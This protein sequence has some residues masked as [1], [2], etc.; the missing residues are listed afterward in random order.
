MKLFSSYLKE[1][2][3][4][5]RGFYFYIEIF[6]AVLILVILLFAVKENPVTSSKEFIYYEMSNELK[7][8]L[9]D[10]DIKK[11]ALELVEPTV[12]KMKATT[13]EV[14]NKAT[15]DV[16][17]YAFDKETYQLETYKAYDLTS[18]ELEKTIYMAADEDEMIR[19]THQEKRIG[20]T[21]K[22]DDQGKSSYRYYNQGYE[23]ERYEN[24]L[25]VLH[26]ENPDKL[27]EVY[28]GQEITT[29][30][31]TVLLNN[32]ENLVPVMIIL[33][34]SLM[35]FF[36]VMAYIFLDKDEDVIRAYAVT[37][38][39]VWKYLLSK[40]MVIMTTV[41]ISSSI[42]TIPI[43]G[44]QANYPLFYILLLISTFA[45]SSLGLLV[46]SFFD[47]I[48]KAFGVLYAFVILMMLPALSYFLPS[49]DPLWL[50]LFPTYPLLQAMKEILMVKTDVGYVL[51]YSGVFLAGGILLFFLANQR[52][53][54][55]LTV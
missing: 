47:N 48:S 45:F 2:K 1:M 54:K 29:L 22:I 24:L 5:A 46:A 9:I 27:Q 23:T 16:T 55:S 19:L 49:Y 6:M 32:R 20:A 31:D 14:E 4:A 42:I 52:F 51:I 37:P 36:I 10:D 7:A 17:S 35:S 41:L 34:G 50:R 21:I 43:M 30:G 28:E 38:S 15:G 40:T 53:R 33:M 44:A 8:S 12:F 26:N 39:S 18:G 11:G 25:Y 13:F 3:I